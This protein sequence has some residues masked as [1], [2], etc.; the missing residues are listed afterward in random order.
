[1][2]VVKVQERK[3]I[4]INLHPMNK[5]EIIV[6]GEYEHLIVLCIAVAPEAVIATLALEIKNLFQNEPGVLFVSSVSLAR[7]DYFHIMNT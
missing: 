4:D 7:F 1:M 3:D 2:P 5:I 6:A